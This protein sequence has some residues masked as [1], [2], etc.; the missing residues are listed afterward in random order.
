MSQNTWVQFPSLKEDLVWVG[1]VS[2]GVHGE[3]GV[4]GGQ[5][6]GRVGGGRRGRRLLGPAHRHPAPAHRDQRAAEHQQ[7]EH[8]AEDHKQ[9]ELL[10]LEEVFTQHLLHVLLK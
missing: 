7:Q 4:G 3:A 1:G 10:V 2:V 9:E 8:A 6:D 5:G